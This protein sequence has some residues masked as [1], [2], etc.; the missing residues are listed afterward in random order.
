MRIG[1][2][3]VST[4]EQNLDLQLDEL[5]GQDVSKFLQIK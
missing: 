4:H 1:Y 5:K 2:A 3:R